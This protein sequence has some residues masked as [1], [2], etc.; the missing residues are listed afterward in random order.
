[1]TDA[2]DEARLRA[3]FN[4]VI[5]RHEISRTTYGVDT[6]GESCRQFSGHVQ[7]GWRTEDLTSL[8]D[9]DRQRRIE[10]LARA[11]QGKPFDV[12]DELPL[13]VILVRTGT[14]ES[15]LLIIVHDMSW[16]DDSWTLFFS[17]LSAAYRGR[18]VNGD[19]PQFFA[20]KVFETA[21]ESPVAHGGQSANTPR[22]SPEP[23][24]LS[25]NHRF[26]TTTPSAFDI[27]FIGSGVACSMTLLELAHALLSPGPTPPKLRI[28]V[29]ERDDQPVAQGI[30]VQKTGDLKPARDG[31]IEC[32]SSDA[33]GSQKDQLSRQI[34]PSRMKAG[35]CTLGSERNSG[36]GYIT[37]PTRGPVVE[38]HRET[39]RLARSRP[40]TICAMIDSGRP[41]ERS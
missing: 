32:D 29:V 6:G 18:E 34:A 40:C 3:A 38:S 17:A 7:I 15:V 41:R 4:D 35:A 1:M 27:A 31:D 24:E 9:G 22:L 20:L 19:A 23:M 10:A 30:I 26:V 5:A 28:A 36:S 25:G 11:E 2:L 13:R 8:A 33:S 21:T 16:N 39:L 14:D 12:T 37:F